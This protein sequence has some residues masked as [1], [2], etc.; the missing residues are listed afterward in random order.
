[1]KFDIKKYAYKRGF[2]AYYITINGK[3]FEGPY[4]NKYKVRGRLKQLKG[5]ADEFKDDTSEDD[6]N[7]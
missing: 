5:E 7:L 4:M 6:S 3:Q 1:M 2:A